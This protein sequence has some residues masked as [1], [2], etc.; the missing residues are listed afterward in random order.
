MA[1]KAYIGVDDKARY[2]KEIHI[3]VN[4]V[5]K[6]VKKV[7]LGVNGVAKLVF[8]WIVTGVL[9][10]TISMVTN[11]AF[12]WNGEIFLTDPS[13]RTLPFSPGDVIKSKPYSGSIE[14]KINGIS[15]GKFSEYEYIV[16]NCK[17]FTMY[18]EGGSTGPTVPPVPTPPGGGSTASS[19][20]TICFDETW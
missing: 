3:G 5:A 16:P 1:K 2:I 18:G 9:E 14:V 6:R 12:Y 4:G 17:T 20:P 10:P 19:N 15:Q 13:P 7:Y 8:R 11:V